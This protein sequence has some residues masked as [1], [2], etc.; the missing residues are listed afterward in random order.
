MKTPCFII[1]R[2]SYSP[3]ESHRKCEW[4]DCYAGMGLA[5]MGHCF[6]GGAWWMMSCPE[7]RNEEE[8]LKEQNDQNKIN[9]GTT[10][11]LPEDREADRCD[12]LLSFKATRSLRRN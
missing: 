10:V 3:L 6:A 7:Y 12:G 9:L 4:I 8:W 2:G 1:C 5:G 11:S